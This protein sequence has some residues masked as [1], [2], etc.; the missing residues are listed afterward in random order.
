[1]SPGLSAIRQ[2]AAPAAWVMAIMLV[3]L[4]LG[5]HSVGSVLCIGQDGHLAAEFV[6]GDTCDTPHTSDKGPGIHEGD[7][8]SHCGPCTDVPLPEGSDVDCAS[9]KVES[10]S[11][12]QILL[13]VVATLVPENPSDDHSLV[14]GSYP[15][16]PAFI[17]SE[18][19]SIRSIVLLL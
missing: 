13:P 11:V 5:R 16:T 17:P 2:K 10:G 9:I 12:A 1:M 18:L 4:P 19:P 8:S 14:A 3:L 7:A 6:G 15:E